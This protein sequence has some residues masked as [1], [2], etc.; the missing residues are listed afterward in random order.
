M[1]GLLG[2]GWP[3]A[4]EG[5]SLQRCFNL[6]STAYLRL[7]NGVTTDDL[8]PPNGVTPGRCRCRRRGG[9]RQTKRA[10]ARRAG[11][12]PRRPAEAPGLGH[13]ASVAS[14]LAHAAATMRR[15]ANRG[16]KHSG[17]IDAV[18]LSAGGPARPHG[19]ITRLLAAPRPAFGLL[20]SCTEGADPLPPR[21]RPLTLAD[22]KR[23]N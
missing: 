7:Y 23:Y 2:E 10:V 9:T 14:I 17:G 1:P 12:Q 4:G 21:P 6:C 19:T 15:A 16:K 18:S 22:N 13:S 5:A 8:R 11:E 3:K 20:S